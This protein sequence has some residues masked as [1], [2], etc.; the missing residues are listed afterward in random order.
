MKL[1][2]QNSKIKTLDLRKSISLGAL[3]IFALLVIV[4]T[5]KAQTNPPA[6]ILHPTNIDVNLNPGSPTSG[7]IYLMNTT[8]NALTIQ[9][10]L[11]NFTAQGEEGGVT[12]TSEDT[13]F[14]LSKWIKITPERI[15]IPSGK[16]VTFTYTITP[17]RNA[18]PG[19]HFG[20]IVFG[21][22]PN[23]NVDG[24][25]GSAISQ[26]IAALFL[27][28]IPGK[29]DEQA[30]IVSF[31]S[32]KKFYEFGPVTFDLRVRD[33]GGVHVRPAGVVTV[34]SMFGQKYVFGFEGLNVLP[35]ATRKM[36]VVFDQTWLFGKY[37]ATLALAYGS[38]NSQLYASAEFFAFPWKV[39]LAVFG[40]LLLLF[41]ARKR[42]FKAIKVIARG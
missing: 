33:E 25:A 11:R 35:G 9:T 8:K 10:I 14:S 31:A 18:E 5:L 23:K 2:N 38:K 16:E 40:V 6:L 32:Q 3:F 7:T 22:V 41:F 26:E 34:K 12:I 30:S 13:P 20:S 24:S 1:K 27:A 15:L 28:R 36:P 4:V 39:G 17:P 21:T 19:G 29:V 42:I 37:T